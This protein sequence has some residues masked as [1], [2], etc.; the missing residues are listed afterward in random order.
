MYSKFV[1]YMNPEEYMDPSIFTADSGKRLA[2]AYVP[3]QPYIGL[4]PL[5]V[6]LQKGTVFPN[7][8]IPYPDNQYK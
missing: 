6:A 5:K 3:M 4:L 1:P 7:L 8:V 2:Q